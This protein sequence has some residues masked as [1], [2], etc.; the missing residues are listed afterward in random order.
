MAKLPQ[1]ASG[2]ELGLG[3]VAIGRKWGVMQQEPPPEADVA[4]LLAGAVRLGIRI[5][6]TAPAYASSE[7]RLGNFLTTLPADARA[8]LVV[9]TKAGEHWDFAAGTSFV[10][11]G[12][13]A[14]RRSIDRSL[15]LLQRVDVLQIHKAT[16]EVVDHPDTVAAI[17]HAR[18]CGIAEF[19][20][21]V[22][23][24]DAGLRALETGLYSAL[25]FPLNRSALDL[26]P[27]LPAMRAKRVVPIA[28]RPFAMGGLVVDAANREAAARAAFRFFDEKIGSGIVLTGT[29][30]L[31]HLEEN[32]RSFRARHEPARAASR[33]G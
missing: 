32:V 10:D 11:H 30:K 25:Q 1:A 3:L 27:L 8:E 9:M 7:A 2:L 28:N 16:L 13:D 18:A 33:D 23:S 26:L 22:S 4:A 12:K 6:D 24:L 14:L 15:E 31:S 5:F 21:S 20:A 19:G 17:E 29:G